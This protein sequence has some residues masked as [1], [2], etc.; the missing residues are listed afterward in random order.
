MF[1]RP[2]Q[3]SGNIYVNYIYVVEQIIVWNGIKHGLGFKFY[4]WELFLIPG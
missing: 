1:P 2:T 3:Q 4:M